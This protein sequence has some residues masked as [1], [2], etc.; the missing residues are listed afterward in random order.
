MGV[1]IDPVK[2]RPGMKI[3][4][5][6]SLWVVTSFDHRTPG[7]L[8]S[9]VVTKIRNLLD[10][11]VVEKTFRGAADWPEAADF[12]TRTCQFLY[13]D[14][15]DFHFM[16]SASYDQFTIT[17]DFLGFRANLL[18]PDTDVVVGFWDGKAV[19]IVLP[20]KMVFTVVDTID[21]VSRGNS[22]GNITKDAK[23]DT[24]LVI[25]VPAF[26]KTGDKVR[27]STEDGSYVERA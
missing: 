23:L 7:N 6:G 27:I 13:S 18:I 11:R 12:E 2:L 25:Q 14:G 19:D 10:G 26:I 22:S 17:R 1:T 4:V 15:D 8:R 21:E 16:D 9:F 3:V 24:G 20:P 5:D